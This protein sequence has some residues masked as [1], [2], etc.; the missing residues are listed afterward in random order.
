MGIQSLKIRNQFAIGRDV[1]RRR[2]VVSG[3][4]SHIFLEVTN[5]CN[6]SCV[7][8]GRTHDR[9]YGDESFIGNMSLETVKTLEPFYAASSWVIA[10]GLGEP[11]LHPQIDQILRYLKSHGARVSLTS[12]GTVLSE[13]YSKLLVECGVDQIVF[14]IDSPDERVFERVRV[15]AKLK[16]VLRN[17]ERLSN[18]RAQ[19]GAKKPR[20]ILEVVAMAQN[21]DQLPEIADLAHRLDFDEVI[22]QSLFKHFEA[23]YNAFYD[24]SNLAVLEPSDTIDSWQEFCRRIKQYGIEVYSPF[25]SG[26][27]QQYLRSSDEAPARSLKSTRGF[28]G[29]IDSPSPMSHV[30]E[31]VRVEGWFLGKEGVPEVTICLEGSVGSVSKRVVQRTPRPDIL[32]HLPEDF[33]QEPNCGFSET[34]ETKGL[35]PGVYTLLAKVQRDSESTPVSMARQKVLVRDRTAYEMYC[36]QPWTTVYVTWDGKLRT[37]CFHEYE[38][39]SLQERSIEEAWNGERYQQFRAGVRDGKVLSECMDC[40][41][42]KSN[43]D[44][45]VP[46]S[47]WFKKQ[48]RRLF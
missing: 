5:N 20:M 46:V 17:I 35:Q 41:A 11:F 13:E 32:P 16:D 12:N 43:P 33:P 15:G 30:E 4:P 1:S 3:R 21:F 9:R 42:G 25:L 28:L 27:L 26:G 31:T 18:L 40:L 14:S 7:M 8:C 19:S 34:L 6:L 23:G 24:K 39:D 2:E 36:T 45:V 22:V 37:C 47:E 29:F 38:I 10:T 48:L 44:Y